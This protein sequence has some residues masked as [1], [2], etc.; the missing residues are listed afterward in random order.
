MACM[1]VTATASLPPTNRP[2][3]NDSHPPPY[4]HNPHRVKVAL[5]TPLHAR[6]SGDFRKDLYLS[7]LLEQALAATTVQPRIPTRIQVRCRLLGG[8]HT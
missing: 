3:F 6:H 7:C 2:H 1:Q 8:A 4:T 5:G